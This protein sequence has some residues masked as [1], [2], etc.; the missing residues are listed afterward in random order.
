MSDRD[1]EQVQQWMRRQ[2]A[3]QFM[4]D[5]GFTR[6]GTPVT[7]QDLENGW[8]AIITGPLPPPKRSD[9]D[10][11]TDYR[12]AKKYHEPFRAEME[13][14]RIIPYTIWA[15][16]QFGGQ[17]FEEV[18]TKCRDHAAD[19]SKIYDPD[20]SLLDGVW[21][22]RPFIDEARRKKKDRMDAILAELQASD[23]DTLRNQ[24]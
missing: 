2:S 14:Y 3:I 9:F 18:E 1:R 8:T 13:C 5:N 17:T 21:I 24:F 19:R 12:W 16:T 22:E 10:E 11:L 7:V 15:A 20:R 6:S 23:Q 4:R